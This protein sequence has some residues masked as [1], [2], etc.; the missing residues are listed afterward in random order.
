[1]P[2]LPDGRQVLQ[3]TDVQAEARD[4]VLVELR[5]P[6][7]AML[8]SFEPGAHLEVEL[9]N[10]MI[11]HYSLTNDSR[12]RDRYVVGVGRAANGRGGSAFVHQSVRCGLRLTTSQP[13]N[14]F[15]LDA[16]AESYL[17]LAGGIGVTP[18]MSMIRWCEARS[19]PWRLVYATRNCQRTAFYEALR[20]YGS[21]V[22]F[23]FDDQAGA[24]LD[25]REWLAGLSGGQH[26]YC[27]G[28]QALMQAVRSHA[29]HIPARNVHFEYFAAPG[30]A[31]AA[32]PA[33]S[34]F[35]V[36]LRRRG[37]SLLVP[38][39][40]SVLEALEA[41]GVKVPF[42]CREGLCGTCETVVCEGEVEHCD[43][44]LSQEQRAAGKSMMVCVSRARSPVLVLD[45]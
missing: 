42:S 13:R 40:R 38:P 2:S 37:L 30:V 7:G 15:A 16:T 11:R 36:E 39:D 20:E 8:P 1:M 41:N 22:H 32:A 19:R 45:L 3:V 10:G 26:V 44:V 35:R 29:A 33:G 31:D 5:A 24:V 21:R 18:V 6:D 43:Y 25:V 27:C 17:F 14:N 28:P 12:E 34:A 23:H 4:V 9:P